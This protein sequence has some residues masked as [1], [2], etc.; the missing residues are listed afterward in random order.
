MTSRWDYIK[1]SGPRQADLDYAQSLIDVMSVD[2][3]SDSE[4]YVVT[5]IVRLVEA[6]ICA[7]L[8]RHAM[9]IE[10]IGADGPALDYL[11]L[12]SIHMRSAADLIKYGAHR[13]LSNE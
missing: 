13:E 10:R 4:R 12:A 11:Q 7:L 1:P 6:D 3:S 9:Q 2:F 5:A 8:E